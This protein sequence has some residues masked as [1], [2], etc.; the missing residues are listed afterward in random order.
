MELNEEI[1]EFIGAFI[2]DGYMGN[3]GKRKNQFVIGFAGDQILDEDYLKNFM[4]PLLLRNFP[5]LN[6]HLYY[7]KDENTLMLRIYSKN[8]F[9]IMESFGFSGGSKTFTVKI[10]R[11]IIKSNK[12]FIKA[13]LRGIFDTDGSIYFDKRPIYKKHYPRIELHLHNPNLI[14]SVNLLLKQFNIKVNMN[15]KFSRI[16][17]N[18]PKNIRNFVHQI[19]FSNER[20][21]SKLRKI[22]ASAEI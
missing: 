5:G 14:K 1:C 12:I 17:I 22:K 7:R 11:S 9:K 13:T 21:L 19:G 10:P 3:Y 18:G 4:I 15:Q 8:L 16:Q 20:H 6:P 2:G